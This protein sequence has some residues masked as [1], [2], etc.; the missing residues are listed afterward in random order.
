ML[1]NCT[2]RIDMP[3]EMEMKNFSF[4]CSE[5][6][7]ELEASCNYKD[8]ELTVEVKPCARCIK[9]EKDAAYEEG[10]NDRAFQIVKGE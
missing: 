6:G 3:G 1:S 2:G 10:W 4:E 7:S 8:K 5:C 9:D